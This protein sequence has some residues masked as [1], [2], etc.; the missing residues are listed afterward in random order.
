MLCASY[1]VLSS[2]L[3]RII[4]RPTL[5]QWTVAKAYATILNPLI[6]W[7]WEVQGREHLETRPAVYI[8]NHQRY[9]YL[10]EGANILVSWMF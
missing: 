8:S 7:E 9:W 6:G 10:L 2:I 5:A 1:G 4:G 3:L